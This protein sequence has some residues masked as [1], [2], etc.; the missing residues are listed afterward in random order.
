MSKK[1]TADTASGVSPPAERRDMASA[2]DARATEAKWYAE[3]ERRGYFVAH[4]NSGKRPF[5]IVLPPPNITGRLHGACPEPF[6]TG[7]R[8]AAEADAGIRDPVPPRHRPCRHRHPGGRGEGARPTGD[9]PEGAGP[10]SVRR[11]RLAV[12]GAVRRRDVDQVKAMGQSLDWSRLRFTMDD[13]LPGPS[14]S[15]SSG[16]MRTVRSTG[17]TRIINWCPRTRQPCPTPSWSTKRSKASSSPSGTTGPTGT[18]RRRRHHA[19]RDDAGD[20]GVAVH[21]GDDRYR[22]LVGATVRHPFTGQ[23][24]PIVVDEAVDPTFEP[25]RSRSRRRTI[26]RTSRSRNDTASRP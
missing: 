6:A 23:D 25:A 12:E 7:H 26:R 10:G 18:A 24:I 17:G 14:G 20:T 11:S 3:W 5:C 9:R 15:P 16:C 1:S 4:P 21:P 22:E 8:G 2:Y 19:R 13:G